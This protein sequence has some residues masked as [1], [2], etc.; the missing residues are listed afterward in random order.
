MLSKRGVLMSKKFIITMDTEG[1]NLW[2][3]RQG[4]DIT[5]ENTL[6]LQRFQDL[7]ENF[8]F[9]PTW[10]S[11][12]EML[13]DDRYIKFIDR[14]ETKQTGEL[15]MHLHAWNSPPDYKL[16]KANDG[17][18]Y[19]IEYPA[20]I[21][22]AKIYEITE[23]IKNRTGISPV[24]HRAGRWATN[25][26]YFRLLDKYGYKVDCS[27]TPGVD[28]TNNV[29]QS[30][31]SAGSNYIDF[32]RNPYKIAGTSLLEVPVTI[33]KSHKLFSPENKSVKGILKSCYRSLKGETLWLRPNGKNL[34]KM[35]YLANHVEKSSSDYLMFMLHSS[36]LMPGG[37]PTFK[38]EAMIEKLYE[39]LTILFKHISKS[40][41]G[42]TLREYLL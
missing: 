4:D 42:C 30:A 17:A 12:Y 14:V 21:M 19:L 13:K 8:G 11:N 10:L 36:E 26:V 22:E 6:F 25:D 15:G 20:E 7:C 37:S 34:N 1:D 23:Y 33:M 38:N 2:N 9:K 31:D 18:P 29:G 5:T 40:Y 24:S 39:D 16:E 27:V 32:S 28:W 3:W 41:Q 35:I